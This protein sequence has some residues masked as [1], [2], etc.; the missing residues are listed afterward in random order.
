VESIPSRGRIYRTCGCRDD[1]RKQLGPRCPL[2]K[3]DDEHGSWAYAVDL[4]HPVKKRDTRRRIGFPTQTEALQALERVI[5]SERTGVF[6]E[7]GMRVGEYLL[8]WL[9]HRKRKLRPTTYTNYSEN[10]HKDLLEVFGQIRLTD[11]RTR[12]INAW[13]HDQLESGRGPMIVYRVAATLRTALNEAWRDKQITYN[14]AR[15]AVNPRPV[16][17]ERLCWTPEQ[18]AAFLRHNATSYADMLADLYEVMLATGLRRGEVL[19]LHWSDVRLMDRALYVRW[20]LAAVNNN[21]IYFGPPKNKSSRNWVSLNA[22]AMAALHRQA[23]Y[24]QALR[25]PGT[26]LEG[27]VFAKPDGTPLRPQWVLSQLRLRSAEIGLPRIGL[28]DLRHTAASIMLMA[29]VPIAVVSKILRHAKLSTTVDLYGHLFNCTGHEAVDTLARI[30][31]E[32]DTARAD[33][34]TTRL[35]FAA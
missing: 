31:D 13:V 7:P 21:K 3:T 11:L 28:H 34:Q 18:A 5:D 29:G 12:H 26:P 10:V 6:E 19:A 15:Y 2:L 32:A 14:P 22:R 27:L 16:S 9:K 24:R 23:G 20:T 33:E 8:E 4:P 30:L 25:P 17:P 35:R 1:Q